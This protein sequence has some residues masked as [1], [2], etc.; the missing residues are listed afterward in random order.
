ME[1]QQTN[2]C[3]AGN[4]SEALVKGL[5]WRFRIILTLALS[6]IAFG[7]VLFN[8]PSV[9]PASWMLLIGIMLLPCALWLRSQRTKLTKQDYSLPRSQTELANQGGTST[10]KSLVW[11]VI[12]AI[13]AAIL[14]TSPDPMMAFLLGIMAGI[15]LLMAVIGKPTSARVRLIK[16]TIFGVA[17]TVVY[18]H[19]LDDQNQVEMLAGKLE[20]YK[21]QHGEYPKQLDVM[22]PALLPEIPKPGLMGFQYSRVA[23]TNSYSLSYRRSINS[24]CYY[25][26]ETKFKCNNDY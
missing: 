20:E 25:K 15:A 22:V 4:V 9:R 1:E 3:Q 13:L 5:N 6:L 8:T 12:S 24:I 18:I 2:T 14:S 19:V 23:D 26:L 11:I 7:I 21:R 17:A 10:K 16:T